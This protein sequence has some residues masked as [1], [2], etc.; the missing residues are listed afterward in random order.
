[1]SVE[2]LQQYTAVSKYARFV[3]ELGRREVWPETVE[4]YQGMLVEKYPGR[5]AEIAGACEAIRR[6][7]V[8]PSM[9]G[10]Q[11]GGTPVFQHNGRLYNCSGS[12]LDRLRFFAEAFYLLLC[13]SGVGFSVQERH[14]KN[15]PALSPKR[16]SGAELPKKAFRVPDNIEGW[17][18]CANVMMSAYHA[19]PVAG[20]ES[21][22]ECEPVFDYSGV[23]EKG[24]RLSF[25]VGRAPGPMPLRSANERVRQVLDRAVGRGGDRLTSVDAYDCAMHWSDA[26]ISGGVRRSA[27]IVLFDLWDEGMLLAKTGN[28]RATNPQ[29]GRS[30]NSA[31][32]VRGRTKYED[33]LKLFEATKEFGEPGFYWTDH[34]DGIPNPC[35]EI[36]FYPFLLVEGT[37]PS[38]GELLRAYQGPVYQDYR[39]NNTRLLSGWQ[40]CN[41]TTING[42]TLPDDPGEKRYE[43]L[44]RCEIASRL[45]TWQAGFTDFPYLGPVSEQIVRREALLGVS[46]AG[47]M[48]HPDALLDPACLRAGAKTVAMHNKR[49]AAL[50]GINPAARTTCVK[51]DGNSAS[52]LGSFS[53]CHPG[54]FRRGMRLVQ[55]NKAEG[56]YL[57]FKSVN[58]QACEPSKWSANGTDDVIRFPVEYQGLMEADLTALEFLS[59]VRT[60]YENWVR[61]GKTVERCTR[62]WLSNNVSNTVRVRD[63]EWGDVAKDIFDHQDSHSGVSFISVY[64][65]RD[66]PQA[67]FTA[68]Y[69]PA[70]QEGMYGAEAL[71]WAPKLVEAARAAFPDLWDACD[72]VL[73]AWDL[74]ARTPTDEQVRVR[75]GVRGFADWNFGGDRRQA[76]Y[77]LKDWWNWQK[78]VELK[79]TFRDVD[80]AEM[81]EDTGPVDFHQEVACAGGACSL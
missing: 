39:T 25:G 32:L 42:K 67:P 63:G 34:P 68:V 44:R 65:D 36:G 64:G 60:I 3:E 52:A 9:R 77:C 80:Y 23:R 70:E 76:T 4:R 45:G 31:I 16:L 19:E 71:E 55:A 29:R 35:V 81:V 33:F 1:M 53:G 26:V 13:G 22:H 2:Q 72:L 62:P 48:H 21:Y 6:F 17:A 49:E 50:I 24:T 18:D 27:T 38:T 40:M 74:A 20:F 11:F 28:W 12:C 5:A 43:F 58:P 78:Y 51:P 30:N 41:L 10:L 56:P 14:L 8:M 57:H 47:V 37:A 15:L 79:A 54:K 59:H 61:P 69:D 75:D 7:E 66:Y 46:I 73:D